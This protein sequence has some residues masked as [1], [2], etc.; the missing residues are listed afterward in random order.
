MWGS[1]MKASRGTIILVVFLTGIQLPVS[2][3]EEGAPAPPALDFDMP[4]SQLEVHVYHR[5]GVPKPDVLPE[6]ARRQEAPPE[7]TN[8]I[9]ALHNEVQTLRDE[10]RL[11][12]DTLNL[13][14]NQIMG[15]LREENE[16]L[17]KE[18]RRLHG[19][20][21]DYGLP[22]MSM[23]PR[24]GG[25]LIDEVLAEPGLYEEQQSSDDVSTEAP[26]VIE[27]EAFSFIVAHEWG[28]TPEMARELSET[29][30][31]LKGMVGIVPLG[32]RREDI[33]RLG[34]DLRA[35]FDEYDNINIEVFDDPSAAR[36]YVETQ[37]GD[38]M[39]RVLSI[40]K[41]SASGRDVILY[42]DKGE[43]HEIAFEQP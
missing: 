32:S 42:L 8:P 35:Q 6:D 3:A 26:S 14:V 34:R 4:T 15:D 17:R 9:E 40:S 11:L 16:T 12:Q 22:D 29:A 20:R 27:P 30:N 41:H 18:V 7:P 28:R 33:E 1:F 21:Q 13:M 24:P 36:H 10:L 2:A 23:L 43:A 38:S 25:E 5:E 19:M 39:R 37:T 31:S